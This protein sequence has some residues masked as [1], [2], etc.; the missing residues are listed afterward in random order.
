M[1]MKEMN[2]RSNSAR[3]SGVAKEVMAKR[4]WKLCPKSMED[5]QYVGI[6]SS[7]TFHVASILAS[8][9]Y[10]WRFDPDFPGRG[11]TPAT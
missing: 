3:A 11:K 2:V 8:P 6:Y 7:L 9:P 1:Q 5:L 10:C 4:P